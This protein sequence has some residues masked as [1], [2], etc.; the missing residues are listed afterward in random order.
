MWAEHLS[1]RT[2][3]SRIWPRTAAIAERFWSQ[4]TCAMWMTCTGGWRRSRLSWKG[5]A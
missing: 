3:D 1:P 4:R 5:L 2:I